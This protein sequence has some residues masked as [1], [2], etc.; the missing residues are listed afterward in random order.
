MQ[1]LP[2]LFLGVVGILGLFLSVWIV[3]PAPIFALLPLSVATPEI[4]PWLIGVHLLVILLMATGAVQGL[5]HRWML[6]CGLVGLALS[7]LP[8]VQFPV[9]HQQAALAFQDLKAELSLS[10]GSKPLRAA[11]FV[12]RDAFL[13]IPTQPTVRHTPQVTVA[14]ADGVASTLDIYRPA[15]AGIYPAIV[16]IHGGAW[17]GGSPADN[18][19]FCRYMAAQGYVVWAISYRF[20]PVHQF[21]TQ[22]TDVQAAL[23][24]IQQHA[25]EYET[26]LTRIALL[27]R[28]AGAQLAMLAAY[29]PDGLPIRAVVNYYGP[30]DLAAGYADPPVPDPINTRAILRD[31]LGGTPA[32]IPDQYQAASPIHWVTR[33]LPPSLLIYGGKDRIVQSKYGRA[34]HQRLQSMGSRA[35]F[36]EI[37]WADHAFDAVFNGVSN[38]LALYYTERFLAWA[39]RS[40]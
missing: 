3:I 7:L 13:G 4:S 16:V 24:F 17:R 34:L 20:A 15:E 29:R 27:G 36:L 9:V 21:P 8:L 19:V 33:P 23:E 18:A 28:S 22:L 1:F 35:V 10:D 12:W 38:Q 30:V 6:G 25:R 40:S 39:L 37:P 32:Q 2:Q 26:D 14:I 11:P 5:F 31:F